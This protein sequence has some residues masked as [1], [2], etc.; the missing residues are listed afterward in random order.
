VFYLALFCGVGKGDFT[1]NF[2]S[3]DSQGQVFYRADDIY[4][5]QGVSPSGGSRSGHD[6]YHNGYI[7]PK[8][9]DLFGFNYGVISTDQSGSGYFLYSATEN[10]MDTV[11]YSGTVWQVPSAEPVVKNSIYEISFYLTNSNDLRPAKIQVVVNGTELGDPV[12]AV[13]DYIT[14]GWQ[15]FVVTWPSNDAPTADFKLVNKEMRGNGND[16]GI[17]T[18]EFVKQ[19]V[20]DYNGNGV[21]DA[22]DYTVWRDRLGQSFTLTN[23]DP[24]A[25]TPN[26]VDQEDYNFW[27]SNFGATS[28]SGSG[29]TAGGWLESSSVPEPASGLIGCVFGLAVLIRSCRR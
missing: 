5:A 29:I 6:Y 28:G 10:R 1:E 8:A 21:V 27:K 24:A 11:D 26:I 3:P 18:I 23:H 13:D 7:I 15:R 2:D 19:P 17:D 25:S 16:F 20:G 14:G 12:S 22:A 9:P 4:L